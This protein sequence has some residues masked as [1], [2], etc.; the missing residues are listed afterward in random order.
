VA[1]DSFYW[2][3]RFVRSKFSVAATILHVFQFTRLFACDCNR[4]LL[5]DG[6]ERFHTTEHSI[7]GKTMFGFSSPPY[8]T[9]QIFDD[10]CMQY[11]YLRAHSRLSIPGFVTVFAFWSLKTLPVRMEISDLCQV[12]SFRVDFE[13]I[14][15]FLNNTSLLDKKRFGL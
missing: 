6:A 15:E 12:V 4:V 14:G 1:K 8:L 11:R 5:L 13:L 7:Y 3:F 2:D 9:L 10:A